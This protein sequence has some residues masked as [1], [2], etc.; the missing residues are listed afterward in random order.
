VYES[1]LIEL[2][3]CACKAIFKRDFTAQELFTVSLRAER[4]SFV[5]DAE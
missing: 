5:Y 1:L 2:Y 3:G 4:A